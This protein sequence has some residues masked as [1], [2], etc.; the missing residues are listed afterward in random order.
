MLTLITCAVLLGD[1]I[2]VLVF[3]KTAGFRH[4]SIP[5]AIEEIGVLAKKKGFKVSFTEDSA[6][7]T[8]ER[9]KDFDVVA[10]VSTTGD[11]LNNA[12]ENCLHRFL[13][14][15]KGFIGVHAA[16]DTEYD[17]PWYGRLVGAYFKG[18]PAIQPADTKIEDRKH[19]TT[20]H[21]PEIWK[22]TDEWYNYRA[23]PR[24]N[25]KVLA[26][27]DESTYKGGDMGADHP[28][29]WC[30]PVDKGRSWYTGMGHTKETFREPLFMEQLWR[31]FQWTSRR[32]N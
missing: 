27:L 25:V 14:S 9:L 10:F 21:L 16:A 26:T 1:P 28:I 32:I 30:K 7:F 11:V 3:T 12:Q 31:A 20:E 2:N 5:V 13:I 23:N 4:D 15:G 24:P 22:R 19:P 29:I 8:D 6:W 17:W 18:H